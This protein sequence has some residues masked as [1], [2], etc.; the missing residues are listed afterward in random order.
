MTIAARSSG[1]LLST[2]ILDLIRTVHIDT[3]GILDE[4]RA[5]AAGASQGPESVRQRA[6]DLAAESSRRDLPWYVQV[7]RLWENLHVR[8]RWLLSA[9]LPGSFACVSS[10]P[11]RAAG[12]RMCDERKTR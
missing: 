10:A 1:N 2:E 9:S 8:G 12:G 4:V 11:T 3:L 5:I 7:D 6:V